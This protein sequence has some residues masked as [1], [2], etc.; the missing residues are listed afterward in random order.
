MTGIFIS[1]AAGAGRDGAPWWEGPAPQAGASLPF[2]HAESRT[3]SP[4]IE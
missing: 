4:K 3:L 2:L 1:Y